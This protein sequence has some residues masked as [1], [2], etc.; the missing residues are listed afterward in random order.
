[1]SYQVKRIDPYWITHPAV[2]LAVAAGAVV[3]A[4]GV[5]SGKTP[6]AAAGGVLVGVGVLLAAK[7]VI[8]AVLGTL[9]LFGGLVTFVLLPNRQMLDMGTG[10]KCVSALFFALLYMVLMDALVLGVAVLYN[11]FGAALG[12]LSVDL[13]GEGEGSGEGG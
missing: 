1:M 12:G 3:G 13:E 6:F 2:G 11:L 9:G 10:W 4:F 7:V 5:L 8:S